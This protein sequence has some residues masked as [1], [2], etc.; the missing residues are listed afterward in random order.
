PPGLRRPG[1][2]DRAVASRAGGWRHRDRRRDARSRGGRV[3]SDRRVPGH[4]PPSAGRRWHSVL[5]PARASG[6]SRTRR[7]THLQLE[8]PLPSL[9][10]G[11]LVSARPPSP[12]IENRRNVLAPPITVRS[13]GSDPA[14]VAPYFSAVADER[15][16]RVVHRPGVTRT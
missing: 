10:R 5:S 2:G 16:T 4:G 13:C 3:G 7:H 12:T 6:G 8:C 1:G 14:S 15:A 9:P 11:A